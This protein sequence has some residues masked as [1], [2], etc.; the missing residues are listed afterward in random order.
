MAEHGTSMPRRMRRVLIAGAC[1][2]ALWKAAALLLVYREVVPNGDPLFVKALLA[3]LGLVFV[4]CGLIAFWVVPNR[5]SL[6]FAGFCLCSGLHWGGPLELPSGPLRTGLILVYVLVTSLVGEVFFLR[7][8]LCFPKKSP[9]D[10]RRP[11]VWVLYAAPIVAAVLAALY[12]AAPAGSSFENAA[13]QSF[14]F[15]T[16]AVGTLFALIAFALI[17]S[18]SFRSGLDGRHRLYVILMVVGMAAAWLPYSVAESI[19]ADSTYWTLT[20]AA[21]PVCF[22]IAFVRIEKGRGS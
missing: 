9:L 17:A 7:F 19:G 5:A 2:V 1:G 12:F 18:H 4:A 3:L 8:A 6:L 20:F 15:V 11:V 13:K 14:F 10:D 22:A 16:S 21:L